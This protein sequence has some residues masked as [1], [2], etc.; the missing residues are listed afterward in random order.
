MVP[1]KTNSSILTQ[2]LVHLLR[3][4]S[5]CFPAT[6]WQVT[7]DAHGCLGYN[8]QS[9]ERTQALEGRK[10]KERT[11]LPLKERHKGCAGSGLPRALFNEQF[12]PRLKWVKNRVLSM[13]RYVFKMGF[14]S[15]DAF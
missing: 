3:F 5:C 4:F 2:P 13:S 11:L 8:V 9:P 14:E 7:C 10:E 15:V 12:P 6:Q 1:A